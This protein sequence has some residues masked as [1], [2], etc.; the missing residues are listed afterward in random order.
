[1]GNESARHGGVPDGQKIR[2]P[3]KT[4]TDGQKGSRFDGCTDLIIL[5]E[6]YSDIDL[7]FQKPKQSCV[8]YE[9][10]FKVMPV[11]TRCGGRTDLHGKKMQI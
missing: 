9:L 8:A 6:T 4:I 3:I 7:R 5:S 10:G 1:M 2:A 11:D